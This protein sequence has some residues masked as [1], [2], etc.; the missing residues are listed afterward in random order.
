MLK[1]TI[2]KDALA[3]FRAALCTDQPID[4]GEGGWT[5]DKMM[6]LAGLCQLLPLAMDS[7]RLPALSY[8][9]QALDKDPV[10][11]KE[12]A[13]TDFEILDADVIAATVCC[14]YAAHSL[15]RGYWDGESATQVV[16]VGLSTRDWEVEVHP[17]AGAEIDVGK[18]MGILPIGRS[19]GPLPS[20]PLGDAGTSDC[21]LSTAHTVQGSLEYLAQAM[22]RTAFRDAVVSVQPQQAEDALNQLL[23]LAKEQWQLVQDLETPPKEAE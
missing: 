5:F 13:D 16:G 23:E 11:L 9:A 20:P 6:M 10:L 22:D 8:K 15:E 3:S 17:V 18:I 12:G 14:R 19:D 4:P 7:K 21:L 1:L 2:S